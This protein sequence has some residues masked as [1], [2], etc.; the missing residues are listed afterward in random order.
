[1][2][3]YIVEGR[4][5]EEINVWTMVSKGMFGCV[6]VPGGRFVC[7]ERKNVGVLNTSLVQISETF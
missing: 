6:F 1:M 7:S 2:Y 3:I 4:L 5:R